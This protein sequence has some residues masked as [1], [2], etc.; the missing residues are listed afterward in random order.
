LAQ[1]IQVLAA[2]G[3][4]FAFSGRITFLDLAAHQLVV[5]NASDDNRYEIQFNPAVLEGD[6]KA[7]LQE[8]ANVT[9]AARFNGQGY[10]AESVTVL[11]HPPE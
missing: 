8:G 1:Q 5:A 3:A 10:I 9:I 7:H 6:A 4:L 2:P 11:S